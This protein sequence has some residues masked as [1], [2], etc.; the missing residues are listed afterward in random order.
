MLQIIYINYI[1]PLDPLMTKNILI[2]FPSILP[3][4]LGLYVPEGKTLQLQVIPIF[5]STPVFPEDREW[6]PILSAL[7]MLPNWILE[8]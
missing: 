6:D 2:T 7:R 8:Y 5:H 4:E 3:L 1:F